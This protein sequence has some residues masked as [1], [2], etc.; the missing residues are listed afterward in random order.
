MGPQF[1]YIS[2]VCFEGEGGI[3]QNSYVMADTIF[4]NSKCPIFAIVNA[5]P[6]HQKDSYTWTSVPIM[7]KILL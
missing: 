5:S 7:L 2:Y 1:Y 4:D 6:N 3:L